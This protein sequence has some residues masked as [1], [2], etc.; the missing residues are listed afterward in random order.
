LITFLDGQLIKVKVGIAGDDQ[1]PNT[2]WDIIHVSY[3][4]KS[5]GGVTSDALDYR[6]IE[7][8]D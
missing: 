7:S 6:S 3:S 4:R 8:T 2:V 1:L 5:H